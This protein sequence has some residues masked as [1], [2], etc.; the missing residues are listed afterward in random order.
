MKPTR[1]YFYRLSSVLALFLLSVS[2]IPSVN[3]QTRQY[4]YSA[5][6]YDITVK[7]DSTFTVREKQT[8]QFVGS[9]H[10][11]LRTIPY[12]KISAITDIKVYDADTGQPLLYSSGTL[13]KTVPSSW[14]RYTYYSSNGMMNIEWY[15]DIADTAHSWIIE[16]TVHG[17]VSFLK[18]HDE[19]YWNLFTDYD[20]PVN[21]VGAI[22]HIPTNVS[23]SSDLSARMYRSY[24]NGTGGRGTEE[25]VDNQTFKFTASAVF[26]K[27]A[28]TIAAGWPKGLVSQAAFWKDWFSIHAS[29]IAM[30]IIILLT[31]LLGFGYWYRKERYSQGRGNIIAQYEPPQNLRPA[32]AE[33]IVKERISSKA[34]AAT[35]IDL[36]V[37]GYVT[38]EEESPSAWPKIISYIALGASSLFF[39]FIFAFLVG[40]SSQT[41]SG[42][43]KWIILVFL[44]PLVGW[45]RFAGKVRKGD[46][47]VPKD[48]IVKQV[49]SYD[50]DP[51]LE[52]YEKKF[53]DTILI[54]AK[55]STKEMRKNPTR[56]RVL[57][58]KMKSLENDLYKETETDIKVFEKP[59]SGEKVKDI[60]L[61]FLF[62]ALAVVFFSSLIGQPIIPE[63]LN[64]FVVL[65]IC[66]LGLFLFVKFEARLNKEGQI[67]KEEWLG[68]KLY[69]QTAERY[70]MQ[71]LTPETFQKY[72]PYAI[73]FG[74]E[75]QW[76]KAFES[77]NIPPPSW[78]AGAYVGGT[79]FGSGVSGAPSFSASAFSSS[80]SSSFVSAFSSSGG[81]GGASGGGGGAGG[82]GGG[83][84]GGAS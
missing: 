15:Y 13:D 78:Y 28:V 79:S 59:I 31:L 64:M 74:V 57:Y 37:R 2:F 45:F 55:F 71:N 83:G 63:P 67:L 17:G 40:I 24:E 81:G 43:E 34:W 58:L 76:G 6:S 9:Y 51:E 16:Y 32:M 22:V 1:K 23:Q 68:F 12:N 56:S 42:P 46:L 70:R 35:V 75:K 18:D 30:G 36:A 27:E 10:K 69:L 38:I 26:P 50:S 77:I 53:L 72:L 80:F 61:M 48:Y 11:G 3:A 29:K 39:I 62:V 33:V 44:L 20:V 60:L 66:V 52:D 25:I 84:G 19:L 5:I 47:L 14:G 73:I 21:L 4:W 82:G 8:Y 54:G 7:N 41:N 65:G 49:K